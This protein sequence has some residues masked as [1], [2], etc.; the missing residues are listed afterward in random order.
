MFYLKDVETAAVFAYVTLRVL[1]G[2]KTMDI[3]QAWLL[4]ANQPDRAHRNFQ[5]YHWTTVCYIKEKH[6]KSWNVT[7]RE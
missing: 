1:V 4:K 3:S 7:L 5:L 6:F 2:K